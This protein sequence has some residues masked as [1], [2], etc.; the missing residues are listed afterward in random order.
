MTIRSE[1][2]DQREYLVIMRTNFCQ[3]CTKTYVV[4][5]HLKDLV[6]TVQM[7]GH[8]IWFWWKISKT[9]IK[10]SLLSRALDKPYLARSIRWQSTTNNTRGG[11]YVKWFTKRPWSLWSWQCIWWYHWLMVNLKYQN[12]LIT[13]MNNQATEKRNS[14]QIIFN[15]IKS[16]TL[17]LS[18][19]SFVPYED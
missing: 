1:T 14:G 13:Y 5:P 11:K 16:T 12:Q 10:D 19:I 18:S 3:F 17:N 2:L 4:T 9:I 7:R 6:E 8:I 15:Q